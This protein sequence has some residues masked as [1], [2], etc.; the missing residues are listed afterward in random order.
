LKSAEQH[1]PWFRAAGL[2]GLATLLTLACVDGGCGQTVE[3]GLDDALSVG[4]SASGAGGSLQLAG[5]LSG[6]TEAGGLLNQAGAAPCQVTECRGKVYQCGDCIDNA[7]QDGMVDALDP[8][9]LGPCDNDE[10]GLSTG[11][12]T[13]Q[14]A[15]CRQDCYFDGDAGPGNDKCQWS[16][17]CDPLSLPPDYPPSGE[18]RCKYDPNGANMGVDCDRFLT[19]QQPECLEACKPLV[20]NGCDCFG[21]CELP[22]GSK[23]YHFIGT[24]QGCQR[25]SLDDSLACPPCTPVPSCFNDCARCETCVDK[26]PDPTCNPGSACQAGAAECGPDLPCGVG[27]YC[28]TGCCVR[29]P[30]PT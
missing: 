28:V 4:G 15:A 21:C 13:S 8:D 20:P 30:K 16:H 11:L 9:C 25:D 6:G 14:S 17:Q 3:V 18:A 22:G 27:E 5:S 2:A 10:S 12:T 7:D 24:A 29:A 23:K 26:V 19:V 1:G